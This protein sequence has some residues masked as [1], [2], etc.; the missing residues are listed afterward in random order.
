MLTWEG[1]T[2]GHGCMGAWVCLFVC[3]CRYL[4]ASVCFWSRILI[5]GALGGQMWGKEEGSGRVEENRELLYLHSKT[6][7]TCCGSTVCHYSPGNKVTVIWI[8][9]RTEL[10]SRR[11]RER[12]MTSM[13]K[14]P[15]PLPKLCV[16]KFCLCIWWRISSSQAAILHVIKTDWNPTICFTA[17]LKK[18]TCS[19]LRPNRLEMSNE[20]LKFLKGQIS[21]VILEE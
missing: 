9:G 5:L 2:R 11:G 4:G 14:I 6:C 19:P 1:G 21:I 12:N 8:R 7:T 13:L 20:E 16:Q 10:T 18:T 3:V 17:L 15:H